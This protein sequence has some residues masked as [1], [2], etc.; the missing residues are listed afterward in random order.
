MYFVQLEV[1]PTEMEVKRYDYIYN[2]CRL[3]KDN[4]DYTADIVAIPYANEVYVICEVD[5][6]SKDA[7]AFE[8]IRIY[9]T[10]KGF[11]QK[12]ID[13]LGGKGVKNPVF[14]KFDKLVGIVYTRLGTSQNDVM[15]L[16]MGYPDCSDSTGFKIFNSCPNNPLYT[17]TLNGYIS[18]GHARVLS[19]LEDEEKILELARRVINEHLSVRDLEAIASDPEYGRKNKIKVNKPT[20]EYEYVAEAFTDKIGNRVRIQ[21]KKIVIPF[22]SEKDLERILEILNVE[23]KVD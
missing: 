6:G 1:T 11:Q 16:M 9:G 19:K 12:T 7:V 3:R 13:N 5:N 14:A 22:N 10:N 18:M 17:N 23:V 2:N 20:N 8:L 21:N 4:Q 15:L